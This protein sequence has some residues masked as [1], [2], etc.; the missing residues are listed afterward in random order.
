MIPQME[1][2]NEK[3]RADRLEDIERFLRSGDDWLRRRQAEGLA[4]RAF[5][6]ERSGFLDR[7]V[8]RLW[9]RALGLFRGENFPAGFSLLAMGGYGREELSPYSDIDLLILH[10]PG[11]TS[12][13]E[14]FLAAFLHPLWDWGLTVGHTVQTPKES[15]RAA[16]KDPD[17]FFPFLDARYLAG[18]RGLHLL[19]REDFQKSTAGKETEL[20]LEIRRRGEVRHLRQGDSVFVLEPELKEGKGGLRDY[21][22]AFW[23]AQLRRG[24]RKPEELADAGLVSRKES[25]TY[26]RALDFLWR[27]RNELHYRYGKREDRLSFDDQE[28]M[29]FSLG[30][31]EKDPFR[32]TESFLKDYFRQ[33]L[34]VYRLSWNVLNRCLEEETGGARRK[35]REAPLEIAAGFT[36]YHGRLALTDP[37]LFRRNP[38]RLWMA[39]ELIHAYGLEPGP[40]LEEKIGEG[41]SQVNER[42]RT[43]P[44]SLGAFL[45]FFERRG[46][47]FRVLEA[48]YETGFLARFLPEFER[49]HCQVQYDRYHIYPVDVHSLYCL[50]E[51]EGLEK[52]DSPQGTVLKEVLEEIRDPGT[53]KLA[54]LFHDLGK[55]EGAAHAAAGERIAAAIGKRLGFSASRTEDLRFLI[56]E[57]LNFVEIAHRRDLNDENLILRF[58]RNVETAE[59]LKMLYV[60]CAADLRAVGPAAWSAWKDA[61]M[62]ELFLKTL[63]LLETGE[64]LGREIRERTVRIQAEVMDLLRGQ[65]PAPRISVFLAGIPPRHYALNGAA[66]IGRQI[67]MAE[68]LSGQKAVLDGEA[69]PEEGCEE[70][71]VAARDEP[72]LFAKISGVLT[73]NHLNILSAEI[74]TWEDGVAVDTFRVHNLID[75]NLFEERR[76]RKVERDLE[77]VLS[78]EKDVRALVEGAAAPL[79]RKFPSSRRESRIEVNNQ[80]SDFYTIVEV[81]THDRP[82]LLYHATQKLFDLELSI[83]MARIA[84]KVDQVV[85][86]FYVQ[87]LSGAKIEDEDF[88]VRIRKELKETLEKISPPR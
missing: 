64:G 10:P 75:E 18:D 73:A 32:A 37:A 62:R 50:R 85:D 29:A 53:L 43:A 42:F 63:H 86:V 77:G 9:K 46:H 6:R 58:A 81:Y 60:L 72:G 12:Q 33:A 14:G 83:A 48:M 26:D 57:H 41:A 8:Q 36:V 82:G 23:A 55:G 7:T 47:L 5:C 35:G 68:K 80:A 88:I 51:I 52:A 30:Y 49:V 59:R 69:K 25:R 17:L 71:T 66:E 74:S 79:F 84:T 27:V 67:L 61:L 4:G 44:E 39:F 56:R 24:I 22:A 15:L 38:L 3:N 70:V 28:A 11:K 16:A 65:I 87:D 78:G 45:S 21:H 34:Q 19:W 1:K 40:D 31:R 13:L 2:E 20:I 76:W 54:A